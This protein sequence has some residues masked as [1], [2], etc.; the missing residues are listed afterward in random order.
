MTKLFPTIRQYGARMFCILAF[1]ALLAPAGCMKQEFGGL[2]IQVPA[3]KELVSKDNPFIVLSV[4][5]GGTGDLAGMKEGDIILSVDGRSLDGL[6]QDH[7]VN[8]LL[9]GEAGSVVMLEIRRDD[10]TLVLRVPRGNIV[11]QK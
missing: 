11:L 5:A 1:F 8:E 9:R 10:T 3:G 4:F 7:V 6:A 2:G